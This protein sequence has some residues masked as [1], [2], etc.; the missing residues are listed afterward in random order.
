MSVWDNYPSIEILELSRQ[1]GWFAGLAQIAKREPVQFFVNPDGSTVRFYRVA[2][3]GRVTGAGSSHV[4]KLVLLNALGF[5]VDAPQRLRK[6]QETC[7]T[8]ERPSRSMAEIT[9]S[10]AVEWDLTPEQVRQRGHKFGPARQQ[11]MAEMVAAGHSTPAIGRFMDGLDHTT[12]M[13]HAR[14]HVGRMLQMMQEAA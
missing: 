11:A 10:V 5:E 3:E 13:Y 12:V 9:D 14:R 7:L 1:D 4:S 8:L 2:D 6:P